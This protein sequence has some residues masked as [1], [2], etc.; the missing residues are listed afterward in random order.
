[1]G[2]P[3][4]TAQTSQVK[5][6]WRQVIEETPRRK[7]PVERR[8]RM[9]SSVNVRAVEIIDQLLHARHDGKAAV[10]R[11]MAEEHVEIGDGILVARWQNIRWPW[12]AH[13]SP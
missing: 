8:Y 1:M 5:W 10:V 7:E 2:V 12:S 4:G 9:S 3:S 13:K 6:K 11:H